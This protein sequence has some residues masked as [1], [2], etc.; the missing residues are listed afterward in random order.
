MLGD[1]EVQPE[2]QHDADEE[3]HHDHDEPVLERAHHH[4]G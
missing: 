3:E 1:A 2:T 4:G